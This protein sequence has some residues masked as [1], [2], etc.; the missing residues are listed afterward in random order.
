MRRPWNSANLFSQRL[1]PTLNRLTILT[2]PVGGRLR[3]KNQQTM[4]RTRRMKRQMI[5]QALNLPSRPQLS[6]SQIR[7]PLSTKPSLA[8]KDKVKTISQTHS[9]KKMKS[10]LQTWPH[11]RKHQAMKTTSLTQKKTIGITTPPQHSQS[12]H[13]SRTLK[14]V[15]LPAFQ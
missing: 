3:P 5:T 2:L 6:Q 1:S 13:H 8:M 4:K 14:R 15:N 9:T 7:N 11:M 10:S 12:S